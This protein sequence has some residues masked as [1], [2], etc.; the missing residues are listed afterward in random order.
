MSQRHKITFG[1]G[2]DYEKTLYIER[3]KGRRSREMMPKVLSFAA[4]LQDLKTEEQTNLDTILQM[5][6][7]FWGLDEFENVLVPYVLGLDN[8]EG[9]E[10]LKNNGTMVEVI[11]AFNEAAGFLIDQSFSRAET[12]EALGKSKDEAPVEAPTAS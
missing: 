4:K 9:L 10:F 5:V 1:E 7:T 6:D 8:P 11:D 3:P 12:Q 2:T